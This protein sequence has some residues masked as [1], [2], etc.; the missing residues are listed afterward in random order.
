[1]KQLRL[2][3][4]ALATAALLPSVTSCTSDPN[5]FDITV[6]SNQKECAYI[7]LHLR[8]EDT[9][10]GEELIPTD[11]EK[12]INKVNI[13]IFDE[14]H[15]LETTKSNVSLSEGESSVDLEVSPGLK[16]IYVTTADAIVNPAKGS[17]ITNFEN[18]KFISSLDKL[19]T[20]SGHVMIGVSDEQQVM[21]SASKDDMPETNNFS[22]KLTRAVAKAQVLAT[23]IDGSSFGI[24]LGAVSF[25]AKQTCE[26]M[27]IKHN[28]S[29][30]F[31]TFKESELNKGTYENFSLMANAKYIAAVSSGF[32]AAGCEY[33]SENIISR[34]LS[35][36]TTF[37]SIKIATTPQKYYSFSA[38][39]AAPNIIE[40]E[41]PATGSTYYVVGIID[42]VN[43]VSDYTVD[44]QSHV[45]TFKDQEDAQRFVTFLNTG[46]VSSMTVSQSESLMKTP[47]VRAG[48]ATAQ[49]E[50]ST[51]TN[52]EAYYRVNIA[53][54]EDD[55]DLTYKVERNKFYKVSINSVKSLGFC[56]ES[57]LRPS[58]PAAVL[59]AEGSSWISA[60]FEVAKWEQVEQD[61]DL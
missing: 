35:G 60:S 43:G 11:E 16:T 42:R 29:D 41:I 18:Q 10:A 59:D 46:E 55:G 45:I 12:A 33:M 14:K 23:G 34:P 47:A 25:K 27:L 61:V 4:L 17:S 51:F 52:G 8:V 40:G 54:K 9:R 24:T 22:I 28:G 26:R 1:M 44:S 31:T 36:N 3:S 32:T 49:F 48:E 57:L 13:Y 19:K 50:V 2:A 15:E 6:T 30:I 37:L 39:D 20:E 38:G 56:E 58:N 21:I 5:P 53:H 7:R